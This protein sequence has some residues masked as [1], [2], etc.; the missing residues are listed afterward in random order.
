MAL[1]IEQ[2]NIA[3]QLIQNSGAALVQGIRQIGQQISGHLT[4]LQTKRDLGAMAQELQ[5]LNVQ[6]NEF[7][8]QLTQMLSRHPLAARDERGQMALS[9]LGKAHGQW[10]AGEAEARAFNRAMAMQTRRTQDARSN[11]EFE[12]EL[13]GKR[14]LNVPGVGLVQPDEIDEVTGQP[15]LL[16]PAAPRAG[17]GPRVLS[18]G[19]VLVDP[20]GKKLA[21]NPTSAKSM[22]EYQKAQLRRGELKDKASAINAE[23]NQFDSD[24]TSAERAYEAAFKREME[25]EDEDEKQKHISTKTELGK[26]ADSLRAEKR[27]RLELLA[28]IRQ[29]DAAAPVEEVVVEPELGAAPPVGVLP[30]PGAVAVPA[31]GANVRR[32]P[33]LDPNGAPLNIREDQ[34]EAAL[35]AGWKRR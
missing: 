25:T 13:R 18:P 5:G 14:P 15:K 11:A 32:V 2:N 8:V 12:E 6:S 16:V 29:E 23:I 1:G 26:I 28:K 30:A 9:I 17:T 20:T 22:T 4:E 3:P 19:A 21:E 27:K 31:A 7:P 34:L 35:Q 33:V 10:Q 24:I